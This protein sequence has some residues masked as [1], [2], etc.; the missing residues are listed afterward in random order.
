MCSSVWKL[1]PL[2][3]DG[4]SGLEF[5]KGGREWGVKEEKCIVFCFWFIYFSISDTRSSSMQKKPKKKQTNNKPHTSKPC[6]ACII[7]PQNNYTIKSHPVQDPL[8][9]CLQAQLFGEQWHAVHNSH[10]PTHSSILAWR[11]PGTE[12]PSGAA[13]YGIAELDTTKVT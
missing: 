5:Q 8:Q 13:V 3:Q 4:K 9:C 12:E 11:I 2:R 7:C 10:T 1:E 6:L